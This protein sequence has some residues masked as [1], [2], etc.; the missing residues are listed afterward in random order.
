MFKSCSNHYSYNEYVNMFTWEGVCSDNL[1]E[2]VRWTQTR[3]QMK[4][5]NI[6]LCSVP[7]LYKVLECMVNVFMLPCCKNNFL[8][9]GHKGLNQPGFIPRSSFPGHEQDRH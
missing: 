4:A 7:Q 8:L 6:Q 5:K 9:L 1:F 2:L 3:L